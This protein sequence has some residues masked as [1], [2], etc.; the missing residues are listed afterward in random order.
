MTEL[1]NDPSIL[2]G[3]GDGGAHLDMLC[4]SG[5]PTYLL[6]TWVRERQ[7]ITQEEAVRRLTS[8]PAEFFGIT[9]RG[10]LKTGLAA[11]ICVYDPE[12]VGSSNRGERRHDLPGGGKRMVMPSRGICHTIVNGTETYA[13]GALTGNTAGQVLRS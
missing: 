2:I 9:D 1:L 8:D 5:Y 3:L 10:R 12:T 13:D 7:A 11:D 4:D 6:G